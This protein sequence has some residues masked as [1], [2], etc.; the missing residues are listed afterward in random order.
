M[1]SDHTLA[2]L[3]P[4]TSNGRP[5]WKTITDTYLY[6]LS[7]KTFL[8]T[9]NSETQSKFYIGY[10]EDDRIFGNSAEQ[11]KIVRFLSV[12]KN[13]TVEFVSM[14]GIKKGHLTVMWNRLYEK[15]YADGFHYFF[16]CGDDINFKT[17]GWV[18]DCI[19]TLKKHNDIGLSGPINNNNRILTQ[20][21]VS[22]KHM[23]IMG[24]FF[25]TEIINWCCDDWI[26]EVYK[27][28]HFYP[29]GA[30]FCSNDGGEERYAINN[31]S[32]FKKNPFQ[33]EK[34]VGHLRNS[35]IPLIKQDKAKIIT[36]S[37]PT[38]ASSDVVSN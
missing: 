12:M 22:R 33:Y 25:P 3:I 10:D 16:Q 24:Y 38:S 14:S 15:A 28:E 23:E 20:S 17:K 1:S 19:A 8:L 30:H 26:N 29:V 32:S 4:C 37:H 9:Y 5:Q 13:V 11:S 31:D 6:N 35:I 27:P 36:F 18:D 34:K 7:L 2:V 21:F